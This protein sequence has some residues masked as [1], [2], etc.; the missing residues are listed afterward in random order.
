MLGLSRSTM[1]GFIKEGFVS[2]VRGRHNEYRFGFQDLVL[3][4]TAQSLRAANV[5]THRILR[6][7]KRLRSRLP[8]ELPLTGLRINAIGDD[9]AVQERGKSVSAESGQFLFDFEVTA[10]PA[11]VLAMRPV[12]DDAS[13]SARDWFVHAE[14][15]EQDDVSSAEAAYRKAIEASPSFINAYLNLGALLQEDGRYREAIEL[16]DTALRLAPSESLL[17]FNRALALEDLGRTE[18][19]LEAYER[20]LAITPEL[21][22]AHWNAARLYEQ[23]D[24]P[25]MALQHYSAYRRLQR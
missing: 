10:S 7:L 18:D 11:A 4:R 3:L 8:A 22:D 20:C 24:Q 25:Q 6:A 5:P 15:A 12:D 16:Y 21:A 19:G 1:V 2:P 13:S 9:V 23:L 14:R 17:H